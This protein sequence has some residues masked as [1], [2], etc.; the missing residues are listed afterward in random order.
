MKDGKRVIWFN[1]WFAQ[2]YNFISLLKRDPRNYI[3]ATAKVSEFVFGAE[4]DLTFTEPRNIDGKAYTEWALS[5]CKEQRV[6][7]FFAKRWIYEISKHIEEFEDIGTKVIYS[8]D[9]DTVKMLSSKMRSRDFMKKGGLCAVPP[10]EVISSAAEFGPAYERIKAACG[11]KSYVCV[12]ADCDEGGVTYKRLYDEFNGRKLPEDIYYRAFEEDLKSRSRVS[13]LVVMPYLMEPEI[14]IDCMQTPGGLIAVP[15]Y[16]QPNHITVL[17]FNEKIMTIAENIS[18]GLKL[19]YPYNIQL[20]MLGDE[21]VFMEVNTRMAG[22]CYKADAVGVNFPQLAVSYAFGD[23]IST[24]SIK[25]G[26]HTV[27]V[28]DISGYV[29]MPEK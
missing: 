21:Y 28:G 13:P 7:V 3:I 15:R 19:E 16:K 24:D 14:S 12:K 17:D 8:R 23:P 10:M 1:H 26:L 5:F 2:A 11:E 22:G 18:A 6:D 27:R 29:I 25:A 9:R 20:R 4:A